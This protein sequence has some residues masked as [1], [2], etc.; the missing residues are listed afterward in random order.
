[1]SIRSTLIGLCGLV[2][3]S[4]LA[5]GCQEGLP[6]ATDSAPQVASAAQALSAHG[7]SA[8][9]WANGWISEVKASPAQLAENLYTAASPALERMV[10]TTKAT[11]RSVCGTMITQLFQKSIGLSSNDFF[12]SFNKDMDGTCDVGTVV[13]LHAD[14]TTDKLQ[15]GTSSPNAAQYRYKI[16]NCASTGPIKFTARAH[17]ADVE[18]GDVL[19]VQYPERTDISGHVMLVRTAPVADSALPAGPSG[20]TAFAVGIIDSTSDP[21]GTSTDYPDWRGGNTGQGLGTATYVLYADDNGTIVGSR[22]SATDPTVY[23]TTT[24][25]LAIGGLL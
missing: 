6:E 25:P 4:A 5:A 16:A 15:K 9:D 11:N 3:L 7:Q 14:G 18:A 21:H 10:G 1:M 22:W 23:D 13:V 20:T 17:I 24:H 12:K 8:L 2:S 19:A